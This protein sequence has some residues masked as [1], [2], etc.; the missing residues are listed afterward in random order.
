MAFLFL[1]KQLKLSDKGNPLLCI[2]SV[3]E[4][5]LIKVFLNLEASF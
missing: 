2:F 5:M 4:I 1:E 3:I